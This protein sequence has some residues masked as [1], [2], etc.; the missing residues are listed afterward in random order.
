[1]IP[2][3]LLLMIS[4]SIHHA[5]PDLPVLFDV[6]YSCQLHHF[7]FR[8]RDSHTRSGSVVDMH[9]STP[10]SRRLI[11]ITPSPSRSKS[12][13]I[14][15]LLWSQNFLRKALI[16]ST[17]HDSGGKNL[18]HSLAI[19]GPIPSMTTNDTTGRS[20]LDFSS[21]NLNSNGDHSARRPMGCV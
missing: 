7:L 5:D 2:P 4:S 20:A 9:P 10:T 8:S 19:S 11:S 18:R 12:P 3:E 15:N 16:S 1:M 21:Y 13:G 6:P 14:V 17:F